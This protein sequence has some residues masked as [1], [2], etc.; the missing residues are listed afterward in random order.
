M[1]E[2]GLDFNIPNGAG[3]LA[4]DGQAGAASPAT[5]LKVAVFPGPNQVTLG[6]SQ[7]FSAYKGAAD[8][9]SALPAFTAASFAKVELTDSA[10]TGAYKAVSDAIKECAGATVLFPS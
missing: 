4:I 8:A 1:G 9:E 6:A 10:T 3:A 5:E 2:G 7:L